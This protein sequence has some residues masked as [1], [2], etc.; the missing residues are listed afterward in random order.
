MPGN[1]V[2]RSLLWAFNGLM[3]PA[4]APAP[5]I[6]AML[7]LGVA[8]AIGIMINTLSGGGRCNFGGEWTSKLLGGPKFRT[9]PVPCVLAHGYWIKAHFRTAICSIVAKVCRR[10]H[11]MLVASSLSLGCRTKSC[12]TTENVSCLLQTMRNLCQA[13]VTSTQTLS[14]ARSKLYCVH[15]TVTPPP[16]HRHMHRHT[17]TMARRN[18]E[19]SWW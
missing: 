14:R 7:Q 15:C 10:L 2:M 9:P 3:A 18:N 16:T 19:A 5:F 6:S 11:K 1:Y 13:H 12:R 4:A 8:R 17:K